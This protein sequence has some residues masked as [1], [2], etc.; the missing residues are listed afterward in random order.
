MPTDLFK[1]VL[2]TAG[3]GADA[4]DLNNMR[5]YL[6]ARLFDQVLSAAIGNARSG[7]ATA[8]PELRN[9]AATAPTIYALSGGAGYIIPGGGARQTTVRAGTILQQVGSPSGDAASFLPYTMVDGEFTLTHAVGDATNPRIDVIEVKLEYVDGNNES[10]IIQDPPP[11]VAQSVQS[12]AKKRRVQAT[13]QIVQGTPAASPAFPPL[14]AGF[15]ALGA[16]VVPATHNAV[17]VATTHFSDLR[18]PLGGA[19]GT[20]SPPRAASGAPRWRRQA[21]GRSS[22]HARWVAISGS[23]V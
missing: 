16:V 12:I 13:F 19:R 14:T 10:R 2:Y 6:G 8:P 7:S 4:A 15:A 23:L 9:T 1:D 20:A 22:S 17:F 18:V 5:G 11:S 21:R 3:E